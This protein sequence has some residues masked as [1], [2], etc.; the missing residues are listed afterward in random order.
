MTLALFKNIASDKTMK[1]GRN[2][3][4]EGIEN[5]TTLHTKTHKEEKKKRSEKSC[6]LF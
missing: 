1:T 2:R 4:D 6:N 3:G 5:K